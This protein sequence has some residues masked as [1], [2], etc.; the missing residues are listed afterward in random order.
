MTASQNTLIGC[1][2]THENTGLA[3]SQAISPEQ[4]AATV[5]WKLSEKERYT[6]G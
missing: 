1:D 3:L 2:L 6:S 5:I 4:T